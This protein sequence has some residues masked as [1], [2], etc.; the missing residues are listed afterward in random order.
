MMSF[1]HVALFRWTADST[2]EQRVAAVEAL[3]RL[4]GEVAHLGR[5][6]VGTDAGLA[7]GNADCAVV[8]DFDSRDDYFAYASDPGHLAMIATY[9][10]PIIAERVA[11]Q[12]EI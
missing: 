10:R 4:A 6:V 9:L 3:Q 12:H 7:P 2:H 8:V 11:V 5:L 1:R